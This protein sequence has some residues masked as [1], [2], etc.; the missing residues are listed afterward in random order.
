MNLNTRQQLYEALCEGQDIEY[1]QIDSDTW[2]S[3]D[4]SKFT[5]Y[6]LLNTKTLGY[7]DELVQTD[8]RIKPNE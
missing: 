6:E 1:K 2:E 4:T 7:W 3:L 8:F 5:V